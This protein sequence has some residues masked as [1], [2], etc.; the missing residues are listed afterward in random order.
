ME[1]V[2]A[3]FSLPQCLGYDWLIELSFEVL[4]LVVLYFSFKKVL[5]VAKKGPLKKF[6]KGQVDWDKIF[7]P[8]LKVFFFAIGIYFLIDL[9]C[10]CFSYK[11]I[12]Q[13]LKPFRDTTLVL[14]IAWMVYRWKQDI[15][16]IKSFEKHGLFFALS[17]ILSISLVLLTGLV[18]F[19]IFSLDIVPLLAFGGIGAAALGFAAK[20]VMGSFFSG[21]MLSMTRPFAIGDLILVP[22]KNIEGY[23][24]DMGWSLT[25]IRDKDK[26]SVYLPNSLFS[27]FFVINASRRTGRR[28]LET[29]RLRY[30]DFDKAPLII[31]ELKKTFKKSP[32]IDSKSSVLVF[33][34]EIGT[35]S[36]DV[37]I[38]IYTMA[39]SLS[40]YVLVK[41][42]VLKQVF[43]TIEKHGAQLAYPVSLME[44]EGFIK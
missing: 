26:R 27:N 13:G 17:K 37:S 41:E 5:K 31:E 43:A 40:D 15:L 7:F 38:D 28:I 11:E 21:V 33:I 25:L 10:Q 2:I 8:P 36:I 6:M 44:A 23:I 3:A 18:I 39:V 16:R 30:A 1:Y 19:R 29:F 42:E 14:S 9:L 22:D 24:E 35:Y 12:S 34:N 20:D 32:T 4:I